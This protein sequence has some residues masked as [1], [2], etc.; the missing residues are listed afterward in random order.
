MLH[1][2]IQLL[3]NTA[4]TCKVI[5]LQVIQSI[6]LHSLL[7]EIL[8]QI[9]EIPPDLLDQICWLNYQLCNSKIIPK[10]NS[11]QLV[12]TIAHIAFFGLAR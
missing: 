9:D 2:I 8:S 1:H 7:T 3:G 4:A 11:G 10:T 12:E 6:D 5:C